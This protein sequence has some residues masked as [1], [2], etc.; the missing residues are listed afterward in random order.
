MFFRARWFSLCCELWKRLDHC[1][2]TVLRAGLSRSAEKCCSLIR[3]LSIPR[4]YEW[5]RKGGLLPSG[6][7]P[8]RTGERA[9]TLLLPPGGNGSPKKPPT[10]SVCHPQLSDSFSLTRE[11]LQRSEDELA[12]GDCCAASRLVPAPRTG[13]GLG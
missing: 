12:Q 11:T 13:T 5:S 3:V 10:G 6:A 4:S 9:F 1:T 2:A 8:K 7:R